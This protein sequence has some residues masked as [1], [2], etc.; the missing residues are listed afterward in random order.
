MD[1]FKAEESKNTKTIAEIYKRFVS[2]LSY[3]GVIVFSGSAITLLCDP[4][5]KLK[6]IDV[7]ILDKGAVEAADEKKMKE[8]G[9]S[10]VKNKGKAV[11]LLDEEYH[12]SIDSD[13]SDEKEREIKEGITL[14]VGPLPEGRTLI[15][16]PINKV[17][18]NIVIVNCN[19]IRINV[20]SPAIEIILKYN[21]WL[22]RGSGNLG[23]KDA[24]DICKLVKKFYGSPEKFI[25]SESRLVVSAMSSKYLKFLQKDLKPI[26]ENNNQA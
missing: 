5:R 12:V 3:D 9:F 15:G 24:I 21:L 7:I 4:E 18:E 20:A 13:V 10:I 25:K 16:I 19:G 11:A 14:K 2:A 23:S 26:F 1:E 6:D 22:K 8:A 17:I